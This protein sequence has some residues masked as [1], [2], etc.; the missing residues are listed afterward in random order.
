MVLPGDLGEEYPQCEDI[1]YCMSEGDKHDYDDNLSTSAGPIFIT[2]GVAG[3]LKK[4]LK[5]N[6]GFV[7]LMWY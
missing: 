5:Q 2:T 6:V 7:R 3:I 1:I 4:D